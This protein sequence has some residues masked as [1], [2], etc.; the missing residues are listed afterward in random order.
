VEKG[1]TVKT[2]GTLVADRHTVRRALHYLNAFRLLVAVAAVFVAFSSLFENIE[3]YRVFL[4][5][6]A[7]LTYAGGAIIFLV[8]HLRGRI[9]VSELASFSLVSDLILVGLIL[10]GFGGFETALTILLLFTVGIAGLILDWRTTY[11]FAAIVTVGLIADYLISF[12]SAA[13]TGSLLQTS[14]YGIAAFATATGTLLLGRWGREYQRLAERRGVDLASLGQINELILHKLRSGVVVVDSRNRIRQINEAAWYLLGNPPVGQRSLSTISPPLAERLEQWR[15]T[16][17]DEDEGLLLQ[18]THAAVVPRMM[19]MPGIDDSQATLIFLEDTSVVSRRARDLAQA[20][21]ARLS[22]SIAHEIRN[23][24]GA[25][26]HAAQLLEESEDISTADRKLIGMMLNHSTRMNDIVENVLKLS[27]RE[28][29]EIE[30]VNLTSWLRRLAADFRLQ[31]NLN[32]KRVRLELPSASIMVL[33]DASQL[34][35]AIT[36]LMENALK[37]ADAGNEE[38]VITLRVSPIRGHREIALD[39]IDNGSGIPPEKRAQIFE[40][41][42]TTHRRGSGLGLYLTR[43]LCDANQASLEYVQ[44]PNSGACFRILLKR[45]ESQQTKPSERRRAAV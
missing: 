40:P 14:L 41:F 20:S 15:T 17:R 16:G 25:L 7:A 43:Q 42:F 18:A 12:S 29:A 26:S 31:H 8:Q 34:G 28:R 6:S 19:T 13:V 32:E 35:Q 24:L 38:V 11:L 45:P 44:V 2:F 4:A 23:P 5:Q 33:I 39:I 9:R 1:H 37:H 10:H 21:L 3:G 22:A 30:P 36:N 27:R